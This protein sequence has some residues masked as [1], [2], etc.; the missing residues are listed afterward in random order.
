MVQLFLLVSYFG[1]ENVYW[2]FNLQVV[3]CLLETL[4]MFYPPK[5]RMLADSSTRFSALGGAPS[6]RVTGIFR[7][8][9]KNSIPF[10]QFDPGQ[11]QPGHKQ[12]P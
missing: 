11:F 2:T 5:G 3:F 7:K 10:S 12:A 8:Q 4:K 1:L 6:M 9:A